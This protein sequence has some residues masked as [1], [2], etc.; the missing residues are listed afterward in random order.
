MLLISSCVGCMPQNLIALASDWMVV[1]LPRRWCCLC[2]W[3]R[4]CWRSCGCGR[5]SPSTRPR[6]FPFDY[7]YNGRGAQYDNRIICYHEVT[8]LFLGSRGRWISSWCK[9]LRI[10]D[11]QTIF[12]PTFS[13]NYQQSVV[14]FL[15]MRLASSSRYRFP[16][17]PFCVWALLSFKGSYTFCGFPWRLLLRCFCVTNMLHDVCV[18]SCSV[19]DVVKRPAFDGHVVGIDSSSS[20]GGILSALK[21]AESMLDVAAIVAPVIEVYVGVSAGSIH[22]VV[23]FFGSELD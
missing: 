13:V 20:G 3:D 14:I 12:G 2:P 11:V 10:C 6:S 17:F 21:L 18:S 16:W 23:R 15:S 9:G 19:A 22:A 5:V 4:T 1:L 7:Y 8:V